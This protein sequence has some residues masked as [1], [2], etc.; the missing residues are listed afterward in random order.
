VI[1]GDSN[2]NISDLGVGDSIGG[3]GVYCFGNY[4][5]YKEE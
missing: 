4:K 3:N 5:R 2:D 1:D